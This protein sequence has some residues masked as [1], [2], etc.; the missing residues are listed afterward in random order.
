M[1]VI[2]LDVGGTHVKGGLVEDGRLLTTRRW[3]T[4]A[5]LG[6]DAVVDTVLACAEELRADAAGRGLP[7]ASAGLVV[8]GL[9]DEE[10]GVCAL[11]VNL[12][13]RDLPVR[14]RMSELLGLPVAFGHDVRAGGLAESRLGA[15][16]GCRDLAFVAVG[17]G[18]AAALVIGGRPHAG[19][20]GFAG[21]LGHQVVRPGGDPCGCG[22]RG[23]LETLASAAAVS[24]RYAEATG[25][26]GV[27]A[28][29]VRAMAV[30]G[31]PAALRI[32]TEATEALADALAAL[33]TLLDLERLVIGGGLA[34]AGDS[35]LEPL[36]EGL[37][38]RLTFRPAPELVAAELGPYAGCLGAGLL[39]EDLVSGAAAGAVY[40]A[41]P[42]FGPG[43]GARYV[44]GPGAG[45]TE[46]GPR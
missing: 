39:A 7:V 11:A 31:D 8:P 25:A 6:P 35:L 22:N 34:E 3:P 18:I 37:A 4:G 28:A 12:G 33:T 40:G 2:A 41:V 46:S 26:R 27:T 14:R 5:E 21:E 30:A 24:R 36:R 32:W 29:R 16:R 38:D 20:R 45:R 13:W 15:G 19:A 1:T 42:G 17:T 9:V 23:C 10:A 43:S 44:P